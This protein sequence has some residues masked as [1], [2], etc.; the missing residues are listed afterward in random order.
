MTKKENI[1]RRGEDEKHFWTNREDW[2]VRRP[3]H[4][5]RKQLRPLKLTGVTTRSG[6]NTEPEPLWNTRRKRQG[7]DQTNGRR[8]GGLET[9]VVPDQTIHKGNVNTSREPKRQKLPTRHGSRKRQVGGGSFVFWS[10]TSRGE[11][12]T[13]GK[14]GKERGRGGLWTKELVNRRN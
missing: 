4:D 11:S 7:R 8:E 3:T 12:P 10:R 9:E 13:T 5:G 6:I 1:E 2:V 14:R